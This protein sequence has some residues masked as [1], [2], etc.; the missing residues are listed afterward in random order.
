MGWVRSRS[1]R[2]PKKML[3]HRDDMN[4]AG[5]VKAN[6]ADWENRFFPAIQNRSRS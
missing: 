6:A 5:L 4:R 1:L 2:T 3:V